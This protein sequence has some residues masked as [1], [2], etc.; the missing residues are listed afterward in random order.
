MLSLK[1]KTESA[2]TVSPEMLRTLIKVGIAQNR[3]WIL[4]YLSKSLFG[5]ELLTAKEVEASMKISR[6]TLCRWEAKGWITPVRLGR[7]KRYRKDEQC[8]RHL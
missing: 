7:S 6:S 4:S 1:L 5:A 8:F 3:E 2:I